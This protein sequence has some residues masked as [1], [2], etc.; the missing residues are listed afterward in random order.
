MRPT[1][2][3]YTQDRNLNLGAICDHPS[4]AAIMNATMTLRIR[5]SAISLLTGLLSL[6]VPAAA[7]QP[8]FTPPKIALCGKPA[9]APSSAVCGFA[10]IARKAGPQVAVIGPALL[11]SIRPDEEVTVGVEVR[12]LEQ[13][14][15][16]SVRAKLCHGAG[17]DCASGLA[18][19][20]IGKYHIRNPFAGICT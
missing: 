3:Y 4:A 6:C 10:L 12:E 9:P 15:I 8:Q 2:L 20:R 16:L 19:V 11:A 13:P 17:A 7:A 5:A 14:F 1:T 18:S